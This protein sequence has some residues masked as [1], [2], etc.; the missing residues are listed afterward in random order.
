M[1]F[2]SAVDIWGGDLTRLL[3]LLHHAPPLQNSME[4]GVVS[5]AAVLGIL[6]ESAYSFGLVVFL[7]G[8]GSLQAVENAG[9]DIV[10]GAF[11]SVCA[12][13]FLPGYMSVNYETT[14][15]RA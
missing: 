12:H 1:F 15:K 3:Q 8:K 4:R 7:L 14:T 11:K 5:F 6:P 13:G 9:P 10:G 2:V